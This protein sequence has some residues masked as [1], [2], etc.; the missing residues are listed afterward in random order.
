LS[1]F[2]YNIA[3]IAQTRYSIYKLYDYQSS[4][5]KNKLPNSNSD[6]LFI[7]SKLHV[8]YS[9]YFYNGFGKR[10]LIKTYNWKFLK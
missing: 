4:D 1:T 10:E 5:K 7:Y 6:T 3:Q 8:N 2:E 9:I